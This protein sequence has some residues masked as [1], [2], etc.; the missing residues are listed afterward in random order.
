MI[1]VRKV[2]GG[3]HVWVVEAGTCYAGDPGQAV[4]MFELDGDG[5]I[6]GETRYYPKPFE[7]PTWRAG[8][9]QAIS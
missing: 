4:V 3:G 7:A 2:T 6:T 8:L 9:V 5:L 1:T